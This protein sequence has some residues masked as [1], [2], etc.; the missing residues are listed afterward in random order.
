MKR[1]VLIV[2]FST[3]IMTLFIPIAYGYY[4]RLSIS[5]TPSISIGSWWYSKQYSTGFESYNI[6]SNGSSTNVNIDNQLWNISN[7]VR[8]SSS[9]DSYFNTRG[10][11]F[12]GTSNITTA[13]TFYGVEAI[14]FYFGNARGGLITLNSNYY[15]EISTN[16]SNFTTIYSSTASS[17]FSLIS[18]DVASI[19]DDGYTL[20][21]GDIVNLESAIYIRVR[22]TGSA[23]I[24]T[25]TA[26]LDNLIIHYRSE[27]INH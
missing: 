8:G 22:Y 18:V 10:L 6:T 27:G 1:F 20:D 2:L 21:N 19:I 4:D 11:R 26:N 7:V 5:E 13:N 12:N 17:S 25:R 24:G 3:L 23:L 15:V 9:T 16:G 14:S